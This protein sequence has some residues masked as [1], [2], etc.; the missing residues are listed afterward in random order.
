MVSGDEGRLCFAS[1]LTDPK[2]GLNSL[3]DLP[4]G[5]LPGAQADNGDVCTCVKPYGLCSGHW[6]WIDAWMESKKQA[7]FVR[8]SLGATLGAIREIHYTTHRK[9][10]LKL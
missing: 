7:R 10:A 8:A 3:F 1:M 5:A 9:P 2:R 6:S 4:G